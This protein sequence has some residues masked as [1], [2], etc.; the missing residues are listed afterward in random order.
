[1]IHKK[2]VKKCRQLN[3][4]KTSAAAN[5]YHFSTNKSLDLSAIANCLRSLL[6]CAFLH[7]CTMLEFV[8]SFML[9][10]YLVSSLP[11]LRFLNI[12][13]VIK[14][15]PNP[16]RHTTFPQ[17]TSFLLLM[18][19]CSRSVISILSFPKFHHFCCVKSNSHADVVY[20]LHF[21]NRG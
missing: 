4:I 14:S 13:P 6:S 20:I 3:C 7:T 11:L 15:L 21:N 9:P 8:S 19:F 17:N 10:L 1:M 12:I 2:I 16:S 18:Q 5:M